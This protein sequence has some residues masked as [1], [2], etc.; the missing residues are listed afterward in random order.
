M[1]VTAFDGQFSF[2]QDSVA[3]LGV[4]ER[5]GMSEE[6]WSNFQNS[7]FMQGVRKTED[8]CLRLTGSR[9]ELRAKSDPSFNP[10]DD[11]FTAP[12]S[13]SYDKCVDYYKVL[14]I[15]EYSPLDEVK[16]AYKKLSLVYH[17][18]KT[19]GLSEEVKEEYA[20]IFIELKNAYLTLSDQPTRRQYDRDRDRDKAAFEV[21]GFKPKKRAHFDATEVLKKLQGMQKA[22]GKVVEVPIKAKLEKFFYGG[23]KRIMRQRRIKERD[24]WTAETRAYRVDIP[25]GASSPHE[26]AFKRQGDHNEDAQPDTVKFIITDKPHDIVERQGI[27]LSTK[28]SIYLGEEALRKP[29]VSA[30]TPSVRGRHLLLWGRNPF[31]SCAG[32]TAASLLVRVRGEGI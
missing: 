13:H 28:G 6:Q 14:G 17:P 1:A 9:D 26:C 18:D 30:E 24:V 7:P 16:K 32:V 15:D 25:R 10:C 19:S 31:F 5:K 21:N 22:P 11:D 3:R 29:Y 20:G 12:K 4:R 27:D 8:L 23:H 2:R